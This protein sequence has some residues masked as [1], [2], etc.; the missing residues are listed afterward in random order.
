MVAGTKNYES[1]Y[2]G[3]ASSLDP[4]YGNF[5]GYRLDAG[6]LGAPGGSQTA[7][8][9]NEAVSRIREG[10]NAFEV[11][12]VSPDVSEVIPKQH[13]EEMAALMKLTGVKPSVH[14]PIID[15]AGFGQRGWDGDLAREDTERR[16]FE[17]VEKTQILDPEGNVPI[18][19]HSTGGVPGTEWRPE[20]GVAPGEKK[21]FKEQAF[22]AINKETNEL[23]QLKE[24]RLYS[25]GTKKKDFERGKEDI[26]KGGTL[27]TPR[28]RIDNANV[29]S[30]DS[31]MVN[32]VTYK[33]QADDL[34]ENLGTRQSL[35]LAK[36]NGEEFHQA[37]Q[38]NSETYSQLQKAAA[39]ISHTRLSFTSLFDTAYRY[40]SKE[41]KKL[42]EQMSR[43]WKEEN[44]KL[45]ELENP[46]AREF[47]YS[48][49]IDENFL[50]LK[51]IT[52]AKGMED[53]ETGKIIEDER[54]GAPKVLVPVEEFA[55]EK[56]AE[57]FGNVAFKSYKKFEENS[58]II[59]I[60]NMMQGYAFSRAKDMKELIRKTK[61]Q[62]VKRVTAPEDEGGLGLSKSEAKE[63]AEKLIGVTWD[64]G[65][66]NMMRKAGFKEEDVIAETE[67]IAKYV[68]HIHLTDNFGYT[69]SH[70]PPGMGNV[71]FKQILEKLEKAGV[72]DKARKIVEAPQFVQHFKK[73]PH[74]FVLSAFGSSLYGMKQAPYWN[75]AVDL[76]GNYFGFPL[77]Y[78]TEKHFSTYGS[79]FHTLPEE[80]GGQI[81][82]TQSR[83][84]GTQNA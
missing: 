26:E 79:G 65:H 77:A 11:T 84:S 32:L 34:L 66:L 73:S 35:E 45:N 81:P 53:L 64:V 3:G 7:N 70:L 63:Q 39:M 15:P 55:M 12:M 10:V 50:K 54:Y 60:E 5:I 8:Q 21:R 43:E 82:G 68:K 30:W 36:L 72:L 74:P 52:M 67:E 75:Q 59:A 76:R 18:V 29:T 19:F 28:E 51:E 2:L 62:F 42:L 57:T 25:L 16:L 61:D 40:G 9:L 23:S 58:P 80:L 24:E 41:Q 13:F 1:F 49:S 17:T 33:K 78:M 38:E 46:I 47:S 69:D 83:F 56:S 71:P 31:K 37:L 48:K 22:V 20:E 44:K 14:A 27:M 6:K 4:D